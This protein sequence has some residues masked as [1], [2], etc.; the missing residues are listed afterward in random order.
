MRQLTWKG[1]VLL[2]V[3]AMLCA[4]GLAVGIVNGIV[5]GSTER[6]ILTVEQACVREDIDYILVLGAGI[7]ADGTP[8]D[9]LHDRVVTGVELLY[10]GT[11]GCLLMSGDNRHADYDEVT[12][13]VNLAVSRGTDAAQIEV[14]RLGLSTYDSLRRAKELYGA[15]RVIIVTQ[16]YH[17]YR[18]LYIAEQMG[19]EAY[20]VPADIRAYRGQMLREL[21]EIAA[22]CKDFLLVQLF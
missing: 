17:L 5:I 8:S 13:M 4:I 3:I 19:I 22:R 1:R 20:G 21:R 6:R 12:A 16:K 10:A 14:D 7:K 9:M 11:D 18:A 15:E 2:C